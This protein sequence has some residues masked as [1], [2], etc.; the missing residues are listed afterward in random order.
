MSSEDSDSSEKPLEPLSAFEDNNKFNV[1][2]DAD[3]EDNDK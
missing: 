3:R 2:S 1:L